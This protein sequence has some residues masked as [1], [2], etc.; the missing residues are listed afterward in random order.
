MRTVRRWIRMC[1]LAAALLPVAARGDESP[2]FVRV[3]VP[4]GRLGDI[5][6]GTERYVP[7]S[8][9]EFEAAL[10]RVQQG[11]RSNLVDGVPGV[12]PLLDVVRYEAAMETAGGQVTFAGTATWTVAAGTPPTALPLGG[13]PVGRARDRKSTR[14]NSSHSSVSRMP[15]S[16]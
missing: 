14:L 12:T 2:G 9:R 10:A 4:R 8:A 1:L 15:S 7:M 16:A 5:D 3:H 11:G 6:L 13:L